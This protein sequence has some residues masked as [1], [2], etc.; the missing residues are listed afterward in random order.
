MYLRMAAWTSWACSV[1][2]TLPVPIALQAKIQISACHYNNFGEGIL[3]DR[4][5]S[6]Y[7]SGPL[8]GS[9]LGGDSTQLSGHDVD[10]LA[11]LTFLHGS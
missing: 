11:G 4:L 3:P 9:E 2:A 10:G 5:V 6:N 1:V 8:L 7:Y